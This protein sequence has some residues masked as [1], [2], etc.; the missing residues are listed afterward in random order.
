MLIFA[1]SM[2]ERDSRGEGKR[3]KKRE[4]KKGGRADPGGGGGEKAVDAQLRWIL[5][6]RRRRRLTG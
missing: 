6:R 4:E 5:D 1:V 2:Q 3:K